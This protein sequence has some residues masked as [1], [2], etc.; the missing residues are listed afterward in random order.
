M[1]GVLL[2]QLMVWVIEC[3]F[4]SIDWRTIDGIGYKVSGRC[5]WSMNDCWLGL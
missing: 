5:N 2:K 3:L 4:D 1:V